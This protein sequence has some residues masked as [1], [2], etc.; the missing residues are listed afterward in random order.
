MT[1]DFT[2]QGRNN[3]ANQIDEEVDASLQL[4]VH[5]VANTKGYTG[6]TLFYK[7]SNEIS[8]NVIKQSANF[9]DYV[10]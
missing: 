8:L 3:V 7:E 4:C 2:I 5:A 6:I 9:D 10:K 1:N